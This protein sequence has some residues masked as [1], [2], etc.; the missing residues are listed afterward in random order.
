MQIWELRDTITKRRAISLV[1]TFQKHAET[2]ASICRSVRTKKYAGQHSSVREAAR[3]LLVT[4][5]HFDATRPRS[6]PVL[7]VYPRLTGRV[8][9]SGEAPADALETN[10]P[11]KVMTT[12]FVVEGSLWGELPADKGCLPLD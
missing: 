10:E 9:S 6:L 5:I 3:R 11:T 7:V 12:S 8:C 1:E 2:V 4:R